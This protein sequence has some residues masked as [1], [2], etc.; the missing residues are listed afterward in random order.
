MGGVTK[1]AKKASSDVAGTCCHKGCDLSLKLGQTRCKGR[2]DWYNQGPL[3]PSGS[4]CAMAAALVVAAHGLGL[5]ALRHR[6]GPAAEPEHAAFERS[7]LGFLVAVEDRSS[8]GR[9][10]MQG[11]LGRLVCT[12]Y[13]RLY[14]TFQHGER[15]GAVAKNMDIAV[16]LPRFLEK[17]VGSGDYT[18][19]LRSA[20]RHSVL[21]PNY[22]NSHPIELI[23]G[24]EDS[25]HG[26]VQR[27]TAPN[28]FKELLGRCIWNAPPDNAQ[29]APVA[30][31]V[32]IMHAEHPPPPADTR[33]TGVT[34]SVVMG[35]CNTGSDSPTPTHFAPAVI[36]IHLQDPQHIVC[37][38]FKDGRWMLFDDA[39]RRVVMATDVAVLTTCAQ[40]TPADLERTKLLVGGRGRVPRVVLIVYHLIKR[41]PTSN[42]SPSVS[43]VSASPAYKEEQVRKKQYA[44]A[45]SAMAWDEFIRAIKN[46]IRHLRRTTTRDLVWKEVLSELQGVPEE[47]VTRA[48]TRAFE[49]GL[50]ALVKLH[51]AVEGRRRFITTSDEPMMWLPHFVALAAGKETPSLMYMMEKAMLPQ[52]VTAFQNVECVFGGTVPDDVSPNMAGPLRNRFTSSVIDFMKQRDNPSSIYAG[53]RSADSGGSSSDEADEDGGGRRQEQDRKAAMKREG[54]SSGGGEREDASTHGE[55]SGEKQRSGGGAGA[56]DDESAHGEGRDETEAATHTKVEA[57]K[58]AKEVEAATKPAKVRAETEAAA[59]PAKVA[60]KATSTKPAKVGGRTKATKPAKVRTETEAAARPAKVAKAKVRAETKAA[61]RPAKVAAKATSTKPAKV[62]GRTKAA[63]PDDE[64]RVPTPQ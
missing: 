42:A 47:D 46:H 60:A 34:D 5:H 52:I 17:L 44:A 53:G 49:V 4:G 55:G 23:R 15:R 37:L 9:R 45:A 20:L 11:P 36:V 13:L 24:G 51:A 19:D 41:G 56:R 50:Q 54:R 7:L 57:D 26:V 35:V 25:W 58:V 22:T 2:H 18:G 12:A 27:G 1:T 10:P 28:T 8:W 43:L 30:V 31:V 61:A 48:F 33:L 64:R 6:P 16:L 40:Q 14:A 63:K 32:E 3:N 59:R 21:P 39:S 38:V 29:G 62:G